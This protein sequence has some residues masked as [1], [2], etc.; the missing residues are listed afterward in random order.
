MANAGQEFTRVFNEISMNKEQFISAIKYAWKGTQD[1]FKQIA[2]SSGNA[3]WEKGYI[4]GW[5]DAVEGIL[6]LAEKL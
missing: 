5:K 3:D 4:N 2:G 6:E 1:N